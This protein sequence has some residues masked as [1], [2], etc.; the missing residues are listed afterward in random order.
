MTVAGARLASD[1]IACRT[2]NPPGNEAAACE[3]V[4]RYLREHGLEPQIREL[5]DGRANLVLRIP[6]AGGPGLMLSG[7]LDVVPADPAGWQSPP[8]DPTIDGDRLVG[9]GS[10]DMKGAVAAMVTACARLA[11]REET[12]RGDLVLALTAGE[13]VDSLGAKQL[14]RDG[15]VDGLAWVVIGEPTGMDVG[16]GHKGALWVAAAA[17]GV[18]A[19]GSQP[20]MGENALVKLLRWLT[21][22][23]ELDELVSAPAHPLLGAPTC[24]VNLLEAGQAPN[25]VPDRARAIVDFRT[26]PGQAHGGLLIDLGM[27][28]PGVELSVLRDAPGIVTSADSVLVEA[29]SE[30]SE[31]ATGGQAELRGLPY[32]TDGSVFG[33]ALGAEVVLLGPGDEKLAHQADEWVSLNALETAATAYHDIADRLLFR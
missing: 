3:V 4:A 10:T 14:V 30:A 8:F 7:H 15:I 24:S 27:R 25:I 13:E 29:A 23:E 22:V 21:P 32:V 1:L 16:V 6:G 28:A 9:R 2:E 20:E 33:Q 31:A 17:L 12:P 5:G 18:A 19:H 11:E 26:L